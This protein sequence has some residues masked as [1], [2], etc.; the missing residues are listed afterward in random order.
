V[1]VRHISRSSSATRHPKVYTST[2]MLCPTASGRV[3]RVPDVSTIV[4]QPAANL[5]RTAYLTA[6][7]FGNKLLKYRGTGAGLN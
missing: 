5:S 7:G 1:E 6:Y 3:S 4:G 2:I